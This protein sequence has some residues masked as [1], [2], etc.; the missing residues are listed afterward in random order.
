MVLFS[1]AEISSWREMATL[2]RMPALV[3]PYGGGSRHPWNGQVDSKNHPDVLGT[4]TPHRIALEPPA[5]ACSAN[6]AQADWGTDPE[7]DRYSDAVRLVIGILPQEARQTMNADSLE[8]IG[9]PA[10]D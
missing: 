7:E 4:G 1:E 6:L 5:C 8:I 10:V 9:E 3:S 2:S